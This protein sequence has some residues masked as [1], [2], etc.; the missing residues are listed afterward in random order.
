MVEKA[1]GKYHN[2]GVL[3]DP[4][5]KLVHAYRKV[6]LF[7]AEKA[8]FTPGDKAAIVKTE[9]GTFDL[10]ICMDLLSPSTSAASSSPAQSTS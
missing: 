9:L 1:A 10:T 3:L 2:T 6:H 4:A 8:M 5:G 7:A